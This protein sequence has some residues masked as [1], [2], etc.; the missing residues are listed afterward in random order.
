[1]LCPGFVSTRLWESDRNRPEE[2]QDPEPRGTEQERE[3]GRALLRALIEGAMPAENVADQ[4]LDAV[5]NQRF[6][7]LTH[8]NTGSAVEKRMQS[9][10]RNEN[11]APLEEGPAI[12]MH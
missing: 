12:L 5:L 8:E 2:L 3:E 11:P 9:I 6:Y 7:I 10:L 4:V 1:V